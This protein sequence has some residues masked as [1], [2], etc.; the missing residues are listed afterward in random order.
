MWR[1]YR[2]WKA[3]EY[4]RQFWKRKKNKREKATNKTYAI[5][6]ENNCKAT[7]FNPVKMSITN[8]STK[9]KLLTG[10][11]S[12]TWMTDT[13][14]VVLLLFY[15][16]YMY[17]FVLFCYRINF[18]IVFKSRKRCTMKILNKWNL[19]HLYCSQTK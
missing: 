3:E 15:K 14:K 17:I 1:L 8:K 9:T 13:K 2:N 5:L 18:T 7:N 16:Q 6:R 11:L 10:R 19:V 12:L 4:P